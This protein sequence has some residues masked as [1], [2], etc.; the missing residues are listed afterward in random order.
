MKTLLEE[1]PPSNDRYKKS[2]WDDIKGD[3]GLETLLSEYK[4]PMSIDEPVIPPQQ[5]QQPQPIQQVQQPE[6]THDPKYYYVRGAK[7]G[8]RKPDH[9]IKQ[10]LKKAGLSP[11]VNN[12]LPTDTTIS[13]SFIT[14]ALAIT[15]VDLLFPLIICGVNNHFSPLKIKE[16]KLKL[17]NSQKKELE[18]VYDAAL[19]FLNIKGNP[20]TIAILGTAGI[21]LM[22]FFML[23]QYAKDQLKKE[24]ENADKK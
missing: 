23:R 14:G 19:K 24:Q 1:N 8:Q 2:Y 21:Y 16:E 9:L 17:T 4:K 13:G 20:V 3:E 5:P 12:P 10:E 7:K 18:P 6:N 15:F 11:V 22:N